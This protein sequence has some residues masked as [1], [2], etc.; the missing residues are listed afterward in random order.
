VYAWVLCHPGTLFNLTFFFFYCGAAVL[1]IK[2]R[3]LLIQ[4]QVFCCRAANPI[5]EILL[6]G[7]SI[8]KMLMILTA[9][10]HITRKD[11]GMNTGTGL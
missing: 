3:T 11:T 6:E 5:P 7:N 9:K 10:S 4:K 2:S 8:V 1:A